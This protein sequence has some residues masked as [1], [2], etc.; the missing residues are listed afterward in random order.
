[1]EL[2]AVAYALC[3]L[4]FFGAFACIV[5]GYRLVHARGK[6]ATTP[7]EF[8]GKWGD[9][10]IHLG[11]GS[12]A[13]LMIATSAIWVIAGVVIKPKLEYSNVAGNV[14]TR[15]I[16]SREENKEAAEIVLSKLEKLESRM[17]EN[18]A[19]ARVS[20]EP[21]GTAKDLELSKKRLQALE[22]LTAAQLAE[23]SKHDRAIS[24]ATARLDESE[25]QR[26]EDAKWIADALNRGSLQDSISATATASADTAASVAD[27]AAT[28]AEAAASASIPDSDATEV[29]VNDPDGH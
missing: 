4:L 14:G 19:R 22:A 16:A 18:Y 21:T 3:G 5:I 9:R 10:E 23:I 17:A 26:S 2:V 11:S 24:V 13:S 15:V 7:T 12:L 6:V 8:K 28:S 29:P 25:K 1:M 27:V 20:M